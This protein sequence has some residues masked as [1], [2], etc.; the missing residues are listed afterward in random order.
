M[1]RRGGAVRVGRVRMLLGLLLVGIVAAPMS[2]LDYWNAP[3]S[4]ASGR[5]PTFFTTASGPLLIW[6]ESDQSGDT[7]RAWLWRA[8]LAG[9]QWKKDRIDDQALNFHGTEP[10]L[11]SASMSRQ[12]T[13]AIA[14]P[15][16]ESSFAVSLSTDE[17]RTFQ[18]AASIESAS[19]SVAPRIY[20]NVNGG[21]ILFVT[22]GQPGNSADQTA[23]VLPSTIGIYS[24]VSRDGSSWSP[25]RSIVASDENLAVNFLPVSV[26]LAGRDIVVFQTL[27]PLQGDVPSHYVLM[28]KSSADGG[29]SWGRARP[30]TDFPDPSPAHLGPEN[31]DNQRPELLPLGGGAIVVWER[32]MTKAAQTQIWSA[33]L[34]SAGSIDLSTPAQISPPTGSYML[35]QVFESG[36]AAHVVYL[37]DR[38]KANAVFHAT[39]TAGRWTSESLGLSERSD[40]S[41]A[42]ATA[43][44]RVAV[45]NRRAYVA[46]QYDGAT[47]GRIF[48]L[49]PDE[50]VDQPSLA[51]LNFQTGR[52]SRNESAQVRVNLPDDSSGIRTIAYLWRHA[53]GPTDSAAAPTAEAVWKSGKTQQATIPI[54]DLPATQDGAWS[55][56]VSIEDNAGNRSVPVSL[57]YVR[58]RTPPDPPLVIPPETDQRGFLASNTFTLHWAPP[59]DPDLAG[60]T[61]EFRYVGALQPGQAGGGAGAAP[62]APSVLGSA[63]APGASAASGASAAPLSGLS[64]YEARLVQAAGPPGPPPTIRG[65]EASFS[66]TNVDNGYYLFSVAAIDGVGNVSAVS[67]VLLRADKYIP[68]TIVSDVIATRDDLGRTQLRILG[69][70]YLTDGRIERIVLDRDGA[71]P[72][73]VD[74]SA[75]NGDYRVASDGEIDGFSFEGVETGSYRLGL[76]H[77]LRGWFWTGPVVSVDISGTVKYGLEVAYNP[78]WHAISPRTYAFSIYDAIILVAILFAGLGLLLSLRQTIRVVQEG[79]VV[80]REVHALITGGPMPT[81]EKAQRATTLRRRGAGLRVK[82]TSTIGLLVIF[83][84]LLVSLPLGFFMIRTESSTLAT[85]LQQRALVLLESAA[86]GGRFF[87][88][89]ED[90]VTQLSFLP[91]QAK[92]MEGAVYITITGNSAQAKVA[93]QD[94]VYAT[95]DDAISQKVEGAELVRGQSVMRSSG[96]SADPLAQ[97][98][99]AMAAELQTAA[100]QAIAPNLANK[101]RLNQEKA[102][103]GQDAASAARR[104]EI[105][106]ALDQEDLKIRDTLRSISNRAVGSIPAFDPAKLTTKSESYLYY[107]PIIEYRPSDQLLYRGMVRLEVSTQK[108][109][110]EVRSATGNLIRITLIIA[111]IALGI[112]IIGAFIL[113]SAIVSPIQK[114]VTQIEKIRDTEDKESLD[115]EKIEVATRDEL[116]TLADTVNQMTEGLVKAAKASKELIVGKGIQKMFIPLDAAPGSRAKLSTGSRDEKDFEVFGY[117]EG[118]KGVSGDYWDFKSINSRYHYFIKCDISGK[119]VSAALIMVQVATMVINYFN[120]WKKA[121]PRNI[122]LGDLVYKIN[123]FIEE[124]GFV[125]RFAA[126]TMG[127]WDSQ[128]GMA[129]LCVAGDLK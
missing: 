70:G 61:W 6:Q 115:G 50:H 37:E 90:A 129:Y 108:I 63:A 99:P 83:V 122:D 64:A 112:G 68:H 34:D 13:V 106:N 43:F 86:Q 110:A 103:L 89:K 77:P 25:L 71:P 9:G 79:A 126:F 101:V 59:T 33:R 65:S 24:S 22:Q 100:E 56:F 124:R 111:A 114:L 12:G 16:T 92:A 14:W 127:L 98:L 84:V 15:T 19:T 107:K 95:N 74:H 38:L 52:K 18:R 75:V 40:P 54:L 44:A 5:F 2:A 1:A 23:G 119:G 60:Y 48:M 32:R 53:A 47:P 46:W 3:E 121:M 118:A 96:S 97:K 81:A 69:R 45:V 82:V 113:S 58:K 29:L 94:V 104:T 57:G 73:D 105:N 91:D 85:G 87:L 109:A 8:Y 51:A 11:Y 21:W 88:G 116:Y 93:G 31:F 55:L 17:G 20:P 30:L 123:D 49:E 128:A 102:G 39:L 41:G 62:G 36:G 120:E 66:Q 35:S 42:G 72:Y 26:P 76:Y 117:Y 4:F 67:T 7:G 27:V 10:R 78:S 80:R 125:G 28:I